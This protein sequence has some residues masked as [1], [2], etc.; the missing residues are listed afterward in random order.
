V[1]ST[2][3]ELEHRR[4]LA[5]V[6]HLYYEETRTQAEIARSLGLSRP[7]VQRLL[8]EAR[9]TGIVRIEV[10]P[11][12]LTHAALEL[13]V[14][15]RFDLDEVIVVE[16][17]D[18]D[19]SVR[20]A[21]GEAGARYVERTLRSGSTLALSWG[22]TLAAA[23]AALEPLALRDVQVVQFVGALA[24]STSNAY[25]VG[26]A[27]RAARVL[28]ADLHCVP[29]PGI[30]AA[31]MRDRLMSDPAVVHTLE[32]AKAADLVMVGIGSLEPGLDI[33][34]E[35]VLDEAGIDE[36]RAAGAVGDIALRFFDS[37]GAVLDTDLDRRIVGM[38]LRDLSGLKVV[39]LSGGRHKYEAIRAAVQG[40]PV[41]VLI[42]DVATA[43]R[44]AV[45]A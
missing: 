31:E 38:E 7:K 27:R 23:I 17:S 25:S 44:L 22:A 26:L 15:R 32:M 16:A 20:A 9:R 4:L 24:P 33:A 19:A 45:E 11:G 6:A 39:G 8:S 18:D 2:Q 5:R 34:I 14:E 41:R 13:A 37:D 10:D 36:L 3:A 30:V 43:E 12:D 35:Q 1:A 29:S 28:N 42:T 21:L 40:G